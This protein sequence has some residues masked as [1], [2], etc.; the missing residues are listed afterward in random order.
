[1]LLVSALLTAGYIAPVV[2]PA[3]FPGEE[4]NALSA[5]RAPDGMLIPLSVLA[6]LSL[7]FGL[8]SVPLRN[9]VAAVIQMLW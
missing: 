4:G 5:R 6:G 7:L 8:Y 1:M 9:A 3:F 2:L